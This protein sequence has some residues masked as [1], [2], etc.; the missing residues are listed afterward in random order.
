MDE[1]K[2]RTRL[3]E[4]TRIEQV[5]TG[6]V[7]FNAITREIVI[8]VEVVARTPSLQL[9]LQIADPPQWRRGRWGIG[10]KMLLSDLFQLPEGST[11]PVRA[12]LTPKFKDPPF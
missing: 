1:D 5:R 4:E 2:A 9:D 3:M 12:L 11:M 8:E 7:S 10:V 6:L